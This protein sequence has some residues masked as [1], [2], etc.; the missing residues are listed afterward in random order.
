MQLID[1]LYKIQFET[2]KSFSA[3]TPDSEIKDL[4]YI[5]SYASEMADIILVSRGRNKTKRM[6]VLGK[7]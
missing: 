7:I 4:L 5:I 6:S 1:L 3:I 2:M